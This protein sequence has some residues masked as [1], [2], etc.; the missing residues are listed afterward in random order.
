MEV[1]NEMNPHTKIILY[2]KG[3][4]LMFH[5]WVSSYDNVAHVQNVEINLVYV[6]NNINQCRKPMTIRRIW[7]YTSTNAYKLGMCERWE[8]HFFG[9]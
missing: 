4:I 8:S 1:K 2:F 7:W 3:D 5:A 6:R 9:F